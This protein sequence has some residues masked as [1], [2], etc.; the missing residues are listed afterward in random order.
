MKT[1]TIRIPSDLPFL[2]VPQYMK[3][4][5]VMDMSACVIIDCSETSMAHSAFIGFLIDLKRRTAQNGGRMVLI[6]SEPVHRMFRLL[7]LDAFFS[8]EIAHHAA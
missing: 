1:Q 5:K 2:Q 4:L 8:G 3:E 7:G 6:L